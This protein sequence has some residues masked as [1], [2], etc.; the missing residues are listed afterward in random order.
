MALGTG[1][2]VFILTERYM[3]S[4]ELVSSLKYIAI[5][6]NILFI[7]WILFNGMEEGFRGTVFEKISYVAL[8]GLLAINSVL[9][10]SGRT[11]GK[12]DHTEE[13]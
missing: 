2:F 8:I 6:G 11:A 1:I 10:F 3:W 4:K 13:Y 9:L 5:G 12:T 7:L